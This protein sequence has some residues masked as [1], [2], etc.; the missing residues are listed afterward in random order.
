MYLDVVPKRAH[1]ELLIVLAMDY[2]VMPWRGQSRHTLPPRFPDPR[3]AH[4]SGHANLQN[5]LR[6]C[7]K[8]Q[9]AARGHYS[10]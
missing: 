9:T 6:S 8:S 7:R 4:G 1:V 10:E 2:D 3:C 5:G